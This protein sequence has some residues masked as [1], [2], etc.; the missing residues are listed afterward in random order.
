VGVDGHYE[1]FSPPYYADMHEAVDAFLEAKWSHYES[2]VPKPY[3]E[4]DKAMQGIPRP[5]DET[6]A[7]VKDF[8]QYVY[9]AYGRFPANLDPMYQRLVCQ[10]QHLDP[11]FY[12]EYYPPGA[13]TEQHTRHFERWHPELVGPDGKPP[14]KDA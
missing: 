14:R 9:D 12:D 11:D 7:I 3:L 8:C 10:V 6:I 1:A 2:D 13:I 5:D 4:P